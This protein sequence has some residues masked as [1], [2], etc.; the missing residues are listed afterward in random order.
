[1]NNSGQGKQ[2]TQVRWIQKRWIDS[3]NLYK[4]SLRNIHTGRIPPLNIS[5]LA[6]KRV[7][8]AMVSV[9]SHDTQLDMNID[10]VLD[11]CSFPT[12]DVGMAVGAIPPSLTQQSQDLFP[13]QVW[14]SSVKAK[15]K[16]SSVIKKKKLNMLTNFSSLYLQQ[17]WFKKL[18]TDGVSLILK[19]KHVP[20]IRCK[21]LNRIMYTAVFD[22]RLDWF[23]NNLPPFRRHRHLLIPI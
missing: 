3:A 19:A 11:T 18:W 7:P 23:L 20:H 10:V 21:T 13:T 22:L 2:D 6:P 14:K 16:N 17:L 12:A 4:I 15:T 9:T 1:M 8:L 5:A